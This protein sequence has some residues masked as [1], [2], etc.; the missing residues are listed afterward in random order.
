[1]VTRVV[2]ESVTIHLPRADFTALLAFAAA[3]GMPA[4]IQARRQGGGV[5]ALAVV[6]PALRA[7]VLQGIVAF[8][9][10]R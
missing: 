6:S 1:M 4:L 10:S 2:L 9:I 5:W 7:P 3:G 8:N